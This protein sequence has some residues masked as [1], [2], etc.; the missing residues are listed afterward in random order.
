LLLSKEKQERAEKRAGASLATGF[1]LGALNE[2]RNLTSTNSDTSKRTGKMTTQNKE[3]MD[4]KRRHKNLTSRFLSRQ[5][6]TVSQKTRHCSITL[7]MLVCLNA[8]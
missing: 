6:S 2:A 4:D 5:C 7:A 1:R 3:P 8:L